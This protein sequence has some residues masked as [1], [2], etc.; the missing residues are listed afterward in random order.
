MQFGPTEGGL[1]A[2]ERGTGQVTLRPGE[3]RAVLLSVQVDRCFGNMGVGVLAIP[4]TLRVS[5][6]GI[7]TTQVLPTHQELS[8][9]YFPADAFRE[10]HPLSDCP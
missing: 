8:G 3:A 4:V 2:L 6:V 1:E 10:T 5:Q 7:T 9:L